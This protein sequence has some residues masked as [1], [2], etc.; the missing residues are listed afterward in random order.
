MTGLAC[1][2]KCILLSTVS[3]V[4]TSSTTLSTAERAGGRFVPLEAVT[5]G[6]CA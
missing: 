3:N 5:A 2:K 4:R 1:G 6:S